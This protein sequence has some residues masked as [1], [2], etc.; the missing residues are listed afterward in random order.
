M[1]DAESTKLLHI[2][3]VGVTVPTSGLEEAKAFYGG[4][5]GLEEAPRSEEE[6]GRPG[7]WY[8]LGAT[9][10]HIQCRDKLPEG[11]TDYH[12]GFAVGDVH[13][14]KAEL[15]SKGV[16]IIESAPVAGRERFFVRDPFGNRLEF[17]TMPGGS[18]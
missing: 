17:L 11:E 8:K 3:H 5:L 10:L 7:V 16:E 14:L 18:V 13:A 12:P 2:Q 6:L 9:E 1:T 4:L 15:R